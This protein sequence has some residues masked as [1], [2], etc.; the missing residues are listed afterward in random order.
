M[1]RGV[2]ASEMFWTVSCAMESPACAARPHHSEASPSSPLYPIDI[3]FHTT[4]C[5]IGWCMI[6]THIDQRSKANLCWPPSCNSCATAAMS[7]GVPGCFNRRFFATA[8]GAMRA[9]LGRTTSCGASQTG[10]CSGTHDLA[11]LNQLCTLPLVLQGLL[12][13]TLTMGLQCL[14]ELGP[15]GPLGGREAS[16]F[17]CGCLGRV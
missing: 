14:L 16:T 5:P 8:A 10:Q 12:C 1:V 15:A 13:Q 9:N 7:S 11:G 6:E 17:Q 3:A 4:Q 2:N